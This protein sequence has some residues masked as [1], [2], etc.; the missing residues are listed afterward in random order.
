MRRAV[1]ER[2]RHLGIEAI[3]CELTPSELARADEIFMTNALVGV[4]S[5]N[6]LDARQLSSQSVAAT[7][8]ESFDKQAVEGDDA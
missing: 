8:R 2:C 5:V 3:E 4:Q 1:L 7:L 6:R